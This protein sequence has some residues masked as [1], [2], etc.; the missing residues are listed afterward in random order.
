MSSVRDGRTDKPFHVSSSADTG[1]DYDVVLMTDLTR[2]RIADPVPL[3]PALDMTPLDDSVGFL[4]K[5]AQIAFSGHMHTIFA[6]FDITAVQFSALTVT[7]NNPGIAQGELAAALDVE[8]PRIVPVLDN[9]ERRGLAERR[10]DSQDGR[11][12][13][14]HLTDDG[15]TLL[16]ELQQRFAALEAWLADTLG[17]QTRNRLIAAL[18]IIIDAQR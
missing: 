5:R 4:L 3:P 13:R 16:A 14:I 18:R 15:A 12:R 17:H 8:R 7:A 11:S 6:E 1:D 10:Q 2:R 9:L